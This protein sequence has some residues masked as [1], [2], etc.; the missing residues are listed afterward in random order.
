MRF[1]RRARNAQAPS[2]LWT[3]K[4]DS[5]PHPYLVESCRRAGA[6][7]RELH[8][9][10][11]ENGKRPLG[12]VV[13]LGRRG[14]GR[15]H[16]ITLKVVG[17]RLFM[18]FARAR[19]DAIVVYE[20][21]LVGLYAGLAKLIRRHTVVSLVEG[22]YEHLGK[23]GTAAFK[24]PVRRLA[25]W[26]VDVFVA[27]NELARSYLVGT[28]GVPE[29]KIV[30]GWWLAGLP[31]DLQPMPPEGVVP[32]PDDVP[33]FV[34]AGR[35]IPP[36]GVDLLIEAVAVYDREFGP[37]RLWLL[38]DGPDRAALAELARRRGIDDSVA[39][40]GSVD[41]A[42]LKGALQVSRALVFPTLRDFIGR[43]AVE[44]LTAGTPVVVSPM[45][46]AAETIV[47][48][49]VNGIV[50]DPR[51]PR[52]L[53]EAM[54]RAADPAIASVLREG[55]RRTSGALTPAAGAD[56]ILRAISL[57]ASN[58]HRPAVAASN[59]HRPAVAAS[60]RQPDPQVLNL[61]IGELVE[62]RS[63]AEI[64][65]TLDQRGELESLPF[66][67]EML[68]FCGRRFRVAKLALKLCDTI[69]ATGMYRMRNAVHLDATRC[70]GQGHGGCQAGCNIYWKEAWLRRVGD[71]EPEPTPRMPRCTLPMLSAA[72]RK[73][74]DQV[75]PGDERYSCQ[76]T[77][78][79]RAAPERIPSWDG[80]QYVRDVRSGNAGA[81]AMA[82]TIAVGLFNEYQDASRRRLPAPLRLRSGRRYPFL[83]G[84]LDKT[85]QQAL[86]L[87]PGEL[88]RVKSLEEI[89]ATLD[90]NNANRGMSFDGE[91]VRYCGQ[92][93]RVLRR[94]EQIID[95]ATGKM[96]RFK[97]PCIVL[98]EVTCVGAY[99]RQCPR[100]IYPYW[101]EIWLERVE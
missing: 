8:W 86:D 93:F 83:E 94:V 90:V 11:P 77:G 7:V 22:N 53:A 12:R 44:S 95:E 74:A 64:L 82:R 37:C 10:V 96:L 52:A 61:R 69:T 85:P 17:P 72:T 19:E 5:S 4:D 1:R 33:L 56:A 51:D 80:R 101:R 68:Q 76:A 57:A 41:H 40:L 30:V 9:A 62:V 58:A 65:A 55:V 2:I 70:D 14:A 39:F 32:V 45:T 73:M 84:R 49:G 59:G 87:Q 88:V 38:G 98:A 26:L 67:P 36:K 23:T 6:T 25:A 16:P 89:V 42:T 99:H 91:M 92:E 75:D 97:N 24:L 43:V 35:L 54:H 47:Q 13:S 100:G 66:M 31:A 78:L 28:L 50:V 21:G 15:E 46:G 48:D 79:L 60:R 27:N 18:K 20:L 3:T 71:G 34:Y 81:T 63:Q 29:R